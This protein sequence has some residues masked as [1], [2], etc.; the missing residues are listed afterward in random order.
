MKMLPLEKDQ[1]VLAPMTGILNLPLRLAFRKFGWNL[2]CIG[3]ID[4]NAVAANKD[5]RLINILGKEEHTCNEDKPLLIQLMGDNADVLIQA[6]SIL[7]DKADIFD[8]N[9]GCPLEKVTSKGMG[10][11]LLQ[12]PEKA[13][14]ILKRLTK[15]T[16]KPLTVKIRL[17]HKNNDNK[18]LLFIKQLEEVGISGLIVH[19]RT[20]EQGFTGD[21]DWGKIRLIKEHATIPIIGCGGINNVKDIIYFKES[22]GC[23][24]IMI[25]TGAMKSP[26]LA[27]EY[28]QHLTGGI[29]PAG[30]TFNSLLNFAKEYASQACTI[31]DL[32]SRFYY[33]LRV[34]HFFILR[35]RTKIFI[36]RHS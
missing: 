26:N 14:A 27:R 5:G 17:L 2:T 3:S 6:I 32:S 36:S 9:L 7:E 10:A 22:S 8:M 18:T 4:A 19:A 16:K 11:A 31:S 21:A 23:D 30:R 1:I 20:P 24:N 29:I 33:S 12:Q 28:H 34:L 35:V 13:L 25:G 15:A